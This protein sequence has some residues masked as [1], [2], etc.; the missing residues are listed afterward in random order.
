MSC[1]PAK[2]NLIK[3][4][5]IL[6]IASGIFLCPNVS[7]A[8]PSGGKPVRDKWAL[9]VGVGSFAD[10]KVPKLKYAT[11]D[12]RDFRNYLV[13]EANFA[14]DH[15][16]LL[17][18]EK[19]TQRRVLSELGNKFLARVAKPD[20]LVVLYFSTHGSPASADIR[21]KNFI[22]AYDS[23]PEDLYT[24][25]IEMDKILESINSR[26]LSERVA[27]VLDACHSGASVP[28]AKGLVRCANFDAD[29]LATGSGQLVI[30]SSKPDQ[31]SWESKRYENGVFTRKLLEGLRLK[32]RNT[33]LGDAFSFIEKSVPAEVQEDY[34]A[35]QTPLLRSQWSGNELALAVMPASPQAVPDVVRHMLEPDST[36]AAVT[37]SR[38]GAAKPGGQAQ[39]GGFERGVALFNKG[40][41]ASAIDNLKK[42]IK[43]GERVAD[44][45]FYLARTYANLNKRDEAIKEFSECRQSSPGT[46]RAEYCLQM[47]Q[48]LASGRATGGLSTGAVRGSAATLST[49]TAPQ[50]TPNTPVRTSGATASASLVPEAE[51]ARV[52]SSLPRINH[53]TREKPSYGEISGWS[54]AE[55]ANFQSEASMRVEKARTQLKDAE[56]LLR[57]AQSQAYSIVPSHKA[58]GETE[59]TFKQRRALAEG[60]LS[61]L[62]APFKA[63]IDLRT[64]ILNEED[65]I[66]QTC[67]QAACS[68]G[69]PVLTGSGTTTSTSSSGSC[70]K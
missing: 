58:Y 28:G 67:T 66:L 36:T 20:D 48:Y 25:G 1:R 50:Q 61:E 51:V 19:A 13:N 46:K 52:R 23:D 65:S 49:F 60:V 63:E 40:D 42:A 62:T 45:H 54:K 69:V 64:R 26:V 33:T 30:S 43:N 34:A 16:R 70:K 12:A 5:V 27:L 38:Q 68:V 21:G 2:A 24:T 29:A 3:L 57:R 56:D 10:S 4:Q 14:A 55:Q 17:L 6:A 41:F 37:F 39:A 47:I 53:V 31:Q 11:K 22:V 15:V 44:S 8:E 59:E 7:A 32:G 35:R 9:V 18:N